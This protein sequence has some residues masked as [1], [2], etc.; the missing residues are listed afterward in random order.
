MVGRKYPI[1]QK[2]VFIPSHK[3]PKQASLGVKLGG[4]IFRCVLSTIAA[5]FVITWLLIL[6]FLHFSLF[7]VKRLSSVEC[8][9]DRDQFPHPQIFLPTAGLSILLP[10]LN[11][12]DFFR[13]LLNL[14]SL[15]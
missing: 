7:L 10:F 13:I 5:P 3:S 12:I 11:F 14:D 8:H 9:L 4:S 6:C 1:G 2:R 15:N